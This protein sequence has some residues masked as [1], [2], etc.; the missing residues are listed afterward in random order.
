MKARK[1]NLSDLVSDIILLARELAR[2]K[3]QAKAL[4]LFTHDR[5]LLNRFGSIRHTDGCVAGEQGGHC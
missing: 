2:I 3:K 1:R 4:G 5:E